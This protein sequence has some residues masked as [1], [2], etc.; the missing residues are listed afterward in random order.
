MFDAELTAPDGTHYCV[1][2]SGPAVVLLHGLG[3]DHQMWRRQVA[4]LRERHRVVVID[5]LGHGKSPNV[6]IAVSLDDLVTQVTGV[7]THAGIQAATLV[8]FDLGGS[9]AVS[10]AATNPDEVAA[11]ALVSTPHGRLKA[12]R[13]LAKQ[14]ISQAERY[15]PQAN[16]DS[17][18]QRWFSAAFQVEDNPTV[19]AI[20][21]QIASNDP[22]S[23]LAMSRLAADADQQTGVLARAVTCPSLV[24]CGALDGDSTPSMARHLAGVLKHSKLMI[25]PRQRHMLPIEAE[26][27]VNDAVVELVERGSN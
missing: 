1:V 7:L 24:M 17:A 4:G 2:G 27:V 21:E 12:Q 13:D 8:G 15:G 19:Q 23:Y 10:T 11:V 25:V 6:N 9:V 3:L 16:A 14:R 22:D 26:T 20:R 18:I 5:L